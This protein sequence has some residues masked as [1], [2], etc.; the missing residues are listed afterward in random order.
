MDFPTFREV[1]APNCWSSITATPAIAR[2]ADI[3]FLPL[4]LDRNASRR[5]NIS[6]DRELLDAI[7]DEASQRG[8]TRSAF[9]AGAARRELEIT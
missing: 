4:I 9:L 8:V 5:I 1:I 6:I 7:D 3:A 2:Q